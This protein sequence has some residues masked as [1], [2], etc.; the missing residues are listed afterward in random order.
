[1]KNNIVLKEEWLGHPKGSELVV[2]KTMADRLV[3]QK[4]AVLK[5]DFKPEPELEPELK[6][7]KKP[8]KSKMVK[9]P[10]KAKG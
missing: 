9:T 8:A 6:A 3:Y 4:V 5:E 1:M 10:K 2:A 7:P